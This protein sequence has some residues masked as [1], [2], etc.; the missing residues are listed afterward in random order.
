ME[1]LHRIGG[2]AES[3]KNCA[4]CRGT[5]RVFISRQIGPGMIQQMATQCE[6]CSGQGD[7]IKNQ[8]NQTNL[9]LHLRRNDQ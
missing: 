5:G 2:K 7:T 4:R 9:D 8:F 3:V 1:T 6:E